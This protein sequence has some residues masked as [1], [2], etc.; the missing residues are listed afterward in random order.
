MERVAR[1]VQRDVDALVRDLRELKTAAE[2]AGVEPPTV[3]FGQRQRAN[4]LARLTPAER[5]VA[6]L[7]RDGQ[8][9]AEIA[10]YLKVSI[11]T[12]KSQVA[13]IL[14]KFELDHRW[15]LFGTSSQVF[16]GGSGGIRAVE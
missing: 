9:N 5:R 11:H 12:V 2:I 16:G 1:Q 8:S 10:C 6:A 15:Q 4:T 14:H 7:L 13:S 3:P